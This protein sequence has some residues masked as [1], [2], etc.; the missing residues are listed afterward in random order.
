MSIKTLY[1]GILVIFLVFT[2]VNSVFAKSITKVQI[3]E[4]WLSAY[5][6][7]PTDAT[8]AYRIENGD[9]EPGA[10]VH[11]A[12]SDCKRIGET[13][14]IILPDGVEKDYVV[15]DCAS[16]NPNDPTR[17]WLE[18]NNIVGEIDYYTWKEHGLGRAKLITDR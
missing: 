4:G 13:G 12:V 18:T 17:E 6:K 3:Y 16:R 5:D 15:F 11:L 8:I 9:I 14:T 1:T 2:Q 7:E 10:E